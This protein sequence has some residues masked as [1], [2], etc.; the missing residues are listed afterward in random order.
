METGDSDKIGFERVADRQVPVNVVMGDLG[1]GKTTVILGLAKQVAGPDYRVIWLKNEYG[2]VNVDGLL[3]R[4]RGISAR[5][6]M[7]GCLCCTAIGNLEDAVRQM[8]AVR[9]DRIIIETA[10]SAHPAPIAMELKRFP[11]VILDGFIEVVDAVNFRGYRDRTVVGR[12]HGQYVDFV[13]INKASLVDGRRLDDVIDM[14]TDN[15]S[16]TPIVRTADGTVAADL[17][18]GADGRAVAGKLSDARVSA[19]AKSELHHNGLQSFSIKAVL[20]TTKDDLEELIRGLPVGDIYRVKGAV[21]TADAGWQVVNGVAG[22]VTWQPLTIQPER[23][24]ILFIG[25]SASE[26]EVAVKKKLDLA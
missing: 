12:S 21:L 6:I 3:A 11:D 24:K 13:V 18:F 14:V 9:P 22:R 17:V 4:E 2:D 8:L 20:K 1:S 7:N 5:E 16:D 15:Y 19:D 25:P 10:G 23:S 26:H